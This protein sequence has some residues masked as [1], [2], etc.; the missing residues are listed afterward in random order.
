[1]GAFE[2]LRFPGPAQLAEAAAA[3]FLKETRAAADSTKPFLV[4]LSGGRIAGAFFSAAT[5][6]AGEERIPAVVHFFWGDERCVPPSDLES[7]FALASRLFLRPLAVADAQIHRVHGERPP[8]TGAAEAEAELR[9]L[10]PVNSAGQPIVD[11]VL[12]GMGEE[13]HTASLFPGEPPA[14]MESPAVFRAVIASK[15]PPRRITLGYGALEAARQVWLLASGEG[16]EQ[17]LKDALAGRG[18]S[19]VATLLRL[20][21]QARILTD[22]SF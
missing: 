8:E 4:A 15:P 16:K 7:N 14:V 5:R 6:L 11:L 19:P 13:G 10:A 18:N 3:D 17:A 22:I 1:M 20:R 9:R 21:R 12:L 2:L